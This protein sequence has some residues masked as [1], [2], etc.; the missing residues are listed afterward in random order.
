MLFA[1]VEVQ[2]NPPELVSNKSRYLAS[3]VTRCRNF[4]LKIWLDGLVQ[5]AQGFLR[6]LGYTQR[7]SFHLQWFRGW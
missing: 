5:D 6:S 1:L 4:S 3:S 2:S 7:V